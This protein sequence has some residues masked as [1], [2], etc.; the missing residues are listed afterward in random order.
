MNSKACFYCERDYPGYVMKS[1]TILE[2]NWQAE[3]IGEINILV[4]PHCWYH[5]E[6]PLDLPEVDG[7]DLF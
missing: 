1:E 4:C 3:P 2:Y 7:S 6:A 5:V